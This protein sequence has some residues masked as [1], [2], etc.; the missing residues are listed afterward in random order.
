MFKKTKKENKEFHEE[1]MAYLKK[2][3]KK[4]KLLEKKMKKR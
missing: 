2:L 1:E 3:E 4:M